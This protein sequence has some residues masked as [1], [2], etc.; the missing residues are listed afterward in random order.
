MTP[1]APTLEGFFA[2]RLMS[3]R[4]AS[5]NTIGAYRDT[6]RL[7]LR[8]MED[9]TGRRASRLG[10]EDLDAES[11]GAFLAHL[12]TERHNSVATRNARLAAVHSFF[13]F[14]ALRHPE[15]AGLIAR[16]L[17]IPPKRTDKRV[18]PFLNEEEVGALLESP[19]QSSWVGRRDYAMISVA[20]ETGLRV[21]E[22]VG[23]SCN[24]VHLEGPVAYVR[25]FGKGRKERTTPLLRATT[26]LLR[27]WMRER[28]GAPDD[29]LFPT[30]KGQ[31]LSPDAV[32]RRLTKYLAVAQ[33]ACP[34]LGNKRLSPHVLRHT[35]AVTLLR[36]GVDIVVIALLLGHETIRTTQ[37]YL[38]ADLTLKERALARTTPREVK[39][40]RYRP[41]DPLLAFLENL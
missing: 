36:A 22:L 19:N 9:R 8:F 21:S 37:I 5:P 38:D 12:E 6:F 33:R 25:C 14:A 4:N 39:V 23:L 20:I 1:L 10:I 40:G 35:C 24:D 34:S 17:A 28:G 15:H 13:G 16:V 27:T 29:P 18:V 32:E 11:I 26:A 3:Q 7:L 41:A 30:S 2:E 31:R